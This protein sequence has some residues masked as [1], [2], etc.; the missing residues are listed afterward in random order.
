MSNTATQQSVTL[1]S[2]ND[3]YPD[4][5]FM[6][7]EMRNHRH[8]HRRGVVWLSGLSGSGKSTIC[9]HALLAYIDDEFRL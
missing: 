4:D 5:G 1:I 8:D 9:S 6:T 3:I 2:Q 7:Q